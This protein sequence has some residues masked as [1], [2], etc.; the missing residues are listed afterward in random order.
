MDG[1]F[2]GG[3][4]G[5]VFSPHA[6]QFLLLRRAKHKDFSPGIWECPA[7]RLHQGEGF[8]RA[9]HR[10]LQEELGVTVKITGLLGTTHFY[11]G[12]CIPDHE[13]IGVVYLCELDATTPLTLSTEHDAARWVTLAE[14]RRL[15]VAPDAST[16]F[17]LR[18]L[19]RAALVASGLAPAFTSFNLDADP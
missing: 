11:R 1:R 19:E 5:V 17:T 10:E 7:G 4:A 13:L 3:V 15:L 2:I 6:N 8:E 14:A 12:S 9:L 18:L 16:Q